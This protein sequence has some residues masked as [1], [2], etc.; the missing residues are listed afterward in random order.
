M[1]TALG[2]QTRVSRRLLQITRVSTAGGKED[3]WTFLGS[4]QAVPVFME[5]KCVC[6][7]WS[8][9]TCMLSPPPEAEG[10]GRGGV[11]EHP[12]AQLRVLCL[13]R[14]RHG[15]PLT[16]FIFILHSSTPPVSDTGINCSPPFNRLSLLLLV[17]QR[18]KEHTHTH[19]H[20][21]SFWVEQ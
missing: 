7:R 1:T 3:K 18:E 13:G 19:T 9:H 8:S 10:E 20:T 21:Q 11:S 14:P 17:L 12:S 6:V 5:C 4:S 2:S 15:A 16:L